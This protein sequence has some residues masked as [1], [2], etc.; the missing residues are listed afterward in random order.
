MVVEPEEEREAPDYQVRRAEHSAGIDLGEIHPAVSHDGERTHILN[1]RLLRSK[2]QYQ[3]QVS[4]GISGPP[5]SRRH[6]TSHG[7]WVRSTVA[8]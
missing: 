1:G 4:W 7:L 5:R 8:V 2:R 3:I 6:G